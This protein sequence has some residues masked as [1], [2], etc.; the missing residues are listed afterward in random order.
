MQLRLRVVCTSAHKAREG[1]VCLKGGA[2]GRRERMPKREVCM[3]EAAVQFNCL[4]QA[5]R[6]A[7]RDVVS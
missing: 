1:Q 3:Y 5:E 7:G 2:E 6:V 4:R